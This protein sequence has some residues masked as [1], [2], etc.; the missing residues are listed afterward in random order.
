M[1]NLCWLCV[2]GYILLI[3]VLQKLHEVHRS[4]SICSLLPLLRAPFDKHSLRKHISSF[5]FLIFLSIEKSPFKYL[6]T[7][8]LSSIFQ[9]C[10]FQVLDHQPKVLATTHELV[11][12]PLLSIFPS[13]QSIQP[14]ELLKFLPTE[15]TA[16][17]PCLTKCP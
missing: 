3:Y 5:F 6:S 14:C 13:K 9:S 2:C 15:M 17:Y 10:F 4:L 8:L 1:I 7:I 11:Y 12:K 16:L